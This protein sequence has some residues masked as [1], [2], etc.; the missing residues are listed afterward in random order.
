[1]NAVE[2]A[3]G[4]R[5]IARHARA[6]AEDDRVEARDAELGRRDVDADV[7]RVR[8]DDALGAASARCG[9]R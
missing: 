7:H 8:N 1:M 5:Q 3:P 2:L 4:H 6:A 9:D